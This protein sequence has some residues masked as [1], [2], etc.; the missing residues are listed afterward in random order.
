MYTKDAAW[1]TFDEHQLGSLEI[2][3]LADMVILSHDYDTVPDEA[4]RLMHSVVTI[5]DGNIVYSNGDLLN[6]EGAGED[7]VWYPKASGARCNIE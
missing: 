2:G 7:G 3:K 6:C 1:F 5:V 4:L